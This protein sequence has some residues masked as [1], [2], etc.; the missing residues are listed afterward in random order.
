MEEAVRKMTSLTAR[1]L[2]LHD[3]GL[4][5]PGMWADIAVF[6]PETV[7][8]RSDFTPPE[9]T[10]RYPEGVE[11]LVVNG[12]VTLRDGEHT[13]ALAGRVLRKK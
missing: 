9:A 2:G 12:V 6:D 4:V 3:R 7:I 1:I 5:S 13:G 8:D 10:M 11:H